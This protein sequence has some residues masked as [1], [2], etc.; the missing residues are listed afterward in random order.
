MFYKAKRVFFLLTLIVFLSGSM[1]SGL[2]FAAKGFKGCIS[3]DEI[4]GNG[5]DEDCSGSDLLCKTCVENAISETGCECGGKPYYSGFCCGSLWQTTPCG[6]EIYYVDTNGDDTNSGRKLEPFKTLLRAVKSAKAGDAIFVNPGRHIEKKQISIRVS[7]TKNRPIVIRGNGEDAF[8]D[9]SECKSRNCLEVHFANHIIIE[10]LTIRAS[11]ESGSRGIRLTN[12]EG[13]IIRNNKVYGGNHANIFCSLSDYTIFEN[14]EA[15]NGN[16]GIYASDSSD[17]VIVK[18]NLIHDNRLI[19]LHMNGDKNSGRDGIMSKC[20]ISNNTIFNSST[21]V[22]CDGVVNSIFRNNILFNNGKRGIAFFRGDGSIPSNDNYVIQNTIVMPKGA[23]YAIGLNSGAFQNFFFNNIIFCNGKVPCFSSNGKAKELKI[24]SD[25]NLYSQSVL[26]EIDDSA[27]R[28]GKW[29]KFI[30]K[31][32]NAV[33]K[34]IRG[35]RNDQHSLQANAED[36]FKNFRNNDFRLKQ[37]SLAI[38]NGSAKHSF[39]KDIKGTVRSKNGLPDIGAYEYSPKANNNEHISR[40]PLLKDSTIPKPAL[41]E[42]AQVDKKIN[43]KTI[44]RFENDLGMVF[45]YIEPGTFRMGMDCSTKS[46]GTPSECH[47]VNLTKGF[48]L[49]TTEVTQGQW[50]RVMHNNP[51]F[52]KQCGDNCPVE[53]VSWKN[54]QNFIRQLNETEHSSRYRLP[55]EA[56]WEYVC[57]SGT[58][59]PFSFG[60]CLSTE[61]ANYCGS[62]P[63]EGCQKGICRKKPVPAN[64]FKPNSWGLRNMHGNVWEWCQD[65]LSEYPPGALTDPK[66]P[67]EGT[68]RVIR[69]GGWNSYANACASGNRSGALP[70]SFYANLGFRLVRE[71]VPKRK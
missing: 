42:S 23:Y 18:G 30:R 54:V 33:S 4:C 63:F 1:P 5:I 24:E 40:I 53:Q 35:K 29:E 36:I 15:F 67:P 45:I 25:Y 51:S 14:N 41:K 66:G 11:N 65:W 69:G 64:F 8:I 47:Q 60:R 3:C 26:W 44:R 68:E 28:F 39:G 56:E 55:S 57:R 49:Q 2:A 62:Y 9:L 32:I 21:G 27:Y 22:N 37:Q 52:F 71:D 17:F 34:Y 13:S 58:E 31:N 38:N 6:G 50:K 46:K 20:L 59:T 70:E 19:G 12:S 10:N 43:A 61:N 7:G 48:Y 16:I